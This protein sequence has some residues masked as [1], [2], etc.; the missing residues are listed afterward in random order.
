MRR[1]TA[2]NEASAAEVAKLAAELAVHDAAVDVYDTLD[3]RY[4]RLA[5]DHASRAPQQVRGATQ[6][7]A[8]VDVP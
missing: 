7:I 4:H 8:R 3:E 6:L 5:A 1:I 2:P